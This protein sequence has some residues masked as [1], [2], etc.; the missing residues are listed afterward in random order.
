MEKFATASQLRRIAG[1]V[2]AL[3]AVALLRVYAHAGLGMIALVALVYLSALMVTIAIL[4]DYPRLPSQ[5]PISE[6]AAELER[7]NLLIAT[8]F[9]AERAFRVAELRQ[10]GPHYFV[11]LEDGGILHLSGPYLHDY[12]PGRNPVRY[13]PCSRFIVRRHAQLGHPV[14]ILCEGVVIEPEV[15]APAFTPQDFARGH[16]PADGEILRHVSFDQLLQERTAI[17]SFVP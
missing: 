12:E 8:R 3:I 15:E 11:E 2:F 4:L 10:E 7:Q 16:V 9:C 1:L 6:V 14:D 5:P 17:D 13:F